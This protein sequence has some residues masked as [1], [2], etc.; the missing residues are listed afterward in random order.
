MP[1]RTTNIMDLRMEFVRKAL[2]PGVN[3]RALCR[4]TGIS[5]KTGYKWQERFMTEGRA[6]LRDASRRP[7]STPTQLPEGVVCELVRLKEAHRAWGPRKIRQLY[8]RLHGSAPCESSCK[9]ILGK[10]GLIEPRRPRARSAVGRLT[11]TVAVEGPNDLW[12]VDFKGWWRTTNGQ[13]CEPLT[14]RDAYSRFI[15]AAR[16]MNTTASTAVRAEFER[17]FAE[18]GLPRVIRSDNGVPFAAANG[19]LGLS[20]LSA[21]WMVLGINLD[22]IRPG[23]P[24][25]N[26]DHERMHRDIRSEV[27]GVIGGGLAEQQQ[28]LDVWRTAFNCERPHEAIAMRTPAELYKLSTKRYEGTPTEIIYGPGMIVRRVRCSGTIKLNGRE[29]FISESLIGFDLGLRP[30]DNDRF[31]L[32]FAH[33]QLGTIDLTTETFVATSGRSERLSPCILK[34]A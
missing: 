16:A 10:A 14:V 33:V 12:T 32:W 29:M 20:R 21:W 27:E 6:G 13:R 3:F 24:Q 22:R 31:E 34:T 5:P 26:G 17:L 19:L 25:E 4:D 9:R 7:T 1:W 2:Q 18:Y 11:C 30:I 15:L 28:A 23:H 8:I